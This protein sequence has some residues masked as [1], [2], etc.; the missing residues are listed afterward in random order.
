MER[1]VEEKTT[2]GIMQFFREVN[3]PSKI[4]YNKYIIQSDIDINIRGF[5]FVVGILSYYLF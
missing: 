4:K 5:L 3:F 2:I 1:K